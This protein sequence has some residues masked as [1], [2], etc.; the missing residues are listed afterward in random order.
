MAFRTFRFLPT[1]PGKGRKSDGDKPDMSGEKKNNTIQM[2]NRPS[3]SSYGSKIKISFS[4]FYILH[5]VLEFNVKRN[6]LTISRA[7]LYE[8]I[9]NAVNGNAAWSSNK[10]GLNITHIISILDKNKDFLKK[11]GLW[12]STKNNERDVLKELWHK[13]IQYRKRWDA[14]KLRELTKK[15]RLI[16]S[17]ENFLIYVY[18]PYFWKHPEFLKEANFYEHMNT[19]KRH[20]NDLTINEL[21]DMK[22]MMEGSHKKIERIKR[23]NEVTKHIIRQF[24]RRLPEWQIDPDLIPDLPDFIYMNWETILKPCFD[25]F[26]SKHAKNPIE[27]R[28]GDMLTQQ[29]KHLVDE[30]DY[31]NLQYTSEDQFYKMQ[32]LGYG[33]QNSQFIENGA[34]KRNTCFVT[35]KSSK[36]VG[37]HLYPILN[38]WKV[39]GK[40]GSNSHWNL[41]PVISSINKGYTRITIEKEP[42]KY[43]EVDLEVTEITHVYTRNEPNVP[44]D[45][46]EFMEGITREN[47][48]QKKE[49]IKYVNMTQPI[50]SEEEEWEESEQICILKPPRR[51]KIHHTRVHI[52][53]KS[54]LVSIV[55][56]ERS[57]NY[58]LSGPLDIWMKIYLWRK[59]A[60]EQ[61]AHLSY[62]ISSEVHKNLLSV[63]RS[64]FMTIA[65]GTQKIIDIRVLKGTN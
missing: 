45:V 5:E 26:M 20:W 64:S 7:N 42:K 53:S 11:E 58:V 52:L 10:K 14:L 27:S 49:Q 9:E 40:C 32:V 31:T 8:R 19:D 57:S 22:T 18:A 61:G 43:M 25:L 3:Y 44:V 54:E 38:A 24:D 60:E 39:T 6:N 1:E 16:D 21:K 30:L 65:E 59:Y 62:S 51:E 4:K 15:D 50:L 46:D 2:Q 13:C 56:Q 17:W 48:D 23:G 55:T 35:G 29:M 33:I 34:L 28:E 12:K 41:L 37:D 47:Y 63:L 36:G